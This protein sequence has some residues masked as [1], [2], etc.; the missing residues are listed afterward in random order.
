M[1]MFF[2][3]LARATKFAFQNFWRNFWLSIVTI[4]ILVLTL[5]MITTI[6][7]VKI[8]GDQAVSQVRE[9]VDVAVYFEPNVSEDK[10]LNIQKELQSD[11]RTKDVIYISPDQALIDFREQSASNEVIKEA[12]EALDENPLGGTIIIKANDLED[13]DGLLTIF[14]R[15]E[16]K[17]L[18]QQQDEDFQSN[19]DVVTR[20]AGVTDNISQIGYVLSGIFIV[21]AVLVIFNTIRIAIY[22][23][24]EEISIM[25]LVG[26]TNAFVRAPFLIESVLYGFLGAVITMAVYYPLLRATAPF[27][28]RFFTGYELDVLGYF[29][30]HVYTIFGLLLGLSILISFLSSV[31]AIRR[32]LKV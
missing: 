5:F 2:L 20:L 9:Q 17:D 21:I 4:L 14:D 13:Y 28:D 25:K 31:I 22:T 30:A 10:I 3:T 7:S 32:Y 12:L 27:L 16:N 6:T 15:E 24:R 8:L 29:N 26:A 19:Q 18:V 11:S 1:T 23:H